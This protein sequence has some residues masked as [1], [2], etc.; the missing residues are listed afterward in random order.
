[1]ASHK[2]FFSSLRDAC[3][4]VLRWA[5]SRG[6]LP[7]TPRSRD[8]AALR[9]PGP[10]HST[11]TFKS[12]DTRHSLTPRDATGPKTC[13]LSPKPQ[14]VIGHHA[15]ENPQNYLKEIKVPREA[16]LKAP[17]STVW[18]EEATLQGSR[19]QQGPSRDQEEDVQ[20]LPK[21]TAQTG[22]ANRQVHHLPSSRRSLSPKAGEVSEAVG[23]CGR[24]SPGRGG[25]GGDGAP[26]GVGSGA[27][28][29]EVRGAGP[30]GG[31]SHGRG[32][33][34]PGRGPRRGRCPSG[35]GQDV[36]GSRAGAGRG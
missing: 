18:E 30:G 11:T 33:A 29:G 23:R 16:G 34:S 19:A 36:G 32:V 35:E 10:Q 3:V 12:Q 25:Q 31:R 13:S 28:P 15:E 17:T 26:E 14:V 22:R 1:M 21:P 20:P 9:A 4:R 6:E 7:T 24:G 8:G 2:Q 5:G 27:G